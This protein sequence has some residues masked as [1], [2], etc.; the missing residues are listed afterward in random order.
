MAVVMICG[1]QAIMP[2]SITSGVRT[3]TANRIT[4]PKRVTLRAFTE[5][6]S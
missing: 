4:R 1:N 2:E 6:L 5:R 3:L